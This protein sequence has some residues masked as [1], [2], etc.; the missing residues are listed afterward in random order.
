[1]EEHLLIRCAAI[2]PCWEWLGAISVRLVREPTRPL[3]SG[4]ELTLWE[5]LKYK[6]QGGVRVIVLIWDDKTSH[7]KFLLKTEGVMRTHD[8]ETR[9]FFKHSTVHCVLAPRYASNKLSIFKQKIVVSISYD[10]QIHLFDDVSC[11]SIHDLHCK[12]EG[13]AAYDILTNFEQCWRKATKWRD[14]R[15]RKVM[16]WHNDAL[17]KLDRISWILTPSSLDHNDDE[18][19]H[20]TDEKDPENWHVQV[21][22]YRMSL[23]AE[24]LGLIEDLFNEPQTL[25]CVRRINKLAEEN[26]KACVSDEV[27]EMK[28]HLMK[29][30]IRVERDR[31]I[32]PLPGHES[33][34][35]VGGKVL[36]ANTT[37]PDALT[38]RSP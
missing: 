29:Y 31:R 19:V 18:N 6:S 17:I 15:F 37:L 5:L 11:R 13:P 38:N 24:H 35:D 2:A 10:L 26:W 30:P 7:D 28:G 14:F 22:G 25:S 16:H 3:P 33:F 12:I 4:G 21:Y 34:P 36:G 27:R 32:R 1:M 20:V 9:K 8:E 23:W